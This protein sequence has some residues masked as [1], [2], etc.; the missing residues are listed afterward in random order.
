[1]TTH[2]SSAEAVA[3]GL[4]GHDCYRASHVI[5]TD[6]INR[7]AGVLRL[8]HEAFYAFTD[9]IMIAERHA[10]LQ[11]EMGTN[12]WLAEGGQIGRAHV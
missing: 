12:R 7:D 2:I 5:Y 6:D 11:E 3:H 4:P 10:M 9:S 1:M 8:C